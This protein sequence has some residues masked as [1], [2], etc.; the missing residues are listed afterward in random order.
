M[1]SF[2]REFSVTAP[3]LF[4]IDF[5]PTST[6]AT[7][8]RYDV[9]FDQLDSSDDGVR[10]GWIN[11]ILM[12]QINQYKYNSQIRR[13]FLHPRGERAHRRTVRIRWR[14]AAQVLHTRHWRHGRAVQIHHGRHRQVCV[15]TPQVK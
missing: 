9:L 4:D 3:S 8:P 7:Q 15:R 10:A 5:G 6:N 13:E 14:H 1:P 2:V 11:G 12:N